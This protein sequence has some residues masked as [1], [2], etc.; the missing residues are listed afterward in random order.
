[1]LGEREGDEGDENRE[2]TTTK[3]AA[4]GD[5]RWWWWAARATRTFWSDKP[6]VTKTTKK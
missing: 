4:D 1:M 5:M 3:A 2:R 6:K